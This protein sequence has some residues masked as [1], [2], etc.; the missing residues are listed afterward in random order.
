MSTQLKAIAQ[1]F[2]P[3]SST[4]SPFQRQMA[5]RAPTAMQ[6]QSLL[7]LFAKIECTE[8]QLL[9]SRSTDEAENPHFQ[10]VPR[11]HCCH[12]PM[13]QVPPLGHGRH[14]REGEA[15]ASVLSEPGSSSGPIVP[16]SL[17]SSTPGKRIFIQKP[18]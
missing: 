17:C 14:A 1:S 6:L 16:K 18:S 10:Q 11:C 15:A 13:S 9:M 3:S 5:H 4:S 2:P 8:M 12:Q 7:G